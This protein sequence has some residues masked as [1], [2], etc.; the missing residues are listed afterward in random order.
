MTRGGSVRRPP[1][2]FAPLVASRGRARG[3]RGGVPPTGAAALAIAAA[4]N[5]GVIDQSV[6]GASAPAAIGIAATL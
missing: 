2:W 1:A 3:R 4:A 5:V 6:H